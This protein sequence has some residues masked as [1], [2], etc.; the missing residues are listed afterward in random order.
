MPRPV[1]A[2]VLFVLPALALADPPV[3]EVSSAVEPAAPSAAWHYQ[4][5]LT[6]PSF[7]I[8][9]GQAHASGSVSLT[10]YV[11]PLL[12]DGTHPLGLL[13]FLEHP[14]SLTLAPG[15]SYARGTTGVLLSPGGG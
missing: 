4:A 3:P 7:S 5:G 12:D 10:D 6:V 13:P 15:L 1:A 2:A 8:S 9:S 11:Q 14:N